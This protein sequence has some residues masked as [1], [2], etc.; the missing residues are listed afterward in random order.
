MKQLTCEMCGS[1][2]LIKQDGLFVCQAC[3]TKYSVEEAKKMMIEGTVEVQGT[4]RVDSSD[5]LENLY[6]LARRAKEDNDSESAQKYYEQIAMEKPDDWESQFY[7]VYYSCMNVKIAQMGSSCIRLGNS[8]ESIFGL[9]KNNIRE[10]DERKKAYYEIYT[11]IRP[12]NC[13]YRLG[14]SFGSREQSRDIKDNFFW[15]HKGQLR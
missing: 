2:D 14:N 1:T 12:R 13:K 9:I 6:T 5:K 7:K 11:R 4:V 15:S 3:G 8:I 10:E